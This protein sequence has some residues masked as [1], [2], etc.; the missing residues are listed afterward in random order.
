VQHQ[1]PLS[2]QDRDDLILGAPLLIW[3]C[4]A[5]GACD[6]FNEG[7][8]QFTGRSFAEQ[9][10]DGWVASLHPDDRTPMVDRFRQAL[11][12]QAPFEVAYRLRR[13]DGSYRLVVDRAT[14]RHDGF[15]AFH[16]YVGSC[17]DVTDRLED[18]ARL[19][20]ARVQGRRH[21]TLCTGCGK[22]RDADLTWQP[23]STWLAE[24]FDAEL[25]EG[26]CDS[27][28]VRWERGA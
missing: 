14:P 7:W 16:G 11:R 6:F 3:R 18:L 12:Q 19:V 25:V 27:C 8:L 9:A 20:R 28:E 13:H 26:L 4:N 10:G 15:G 21:A 1:T 5:E 24:R 17:V 2:N 23:L 22:V